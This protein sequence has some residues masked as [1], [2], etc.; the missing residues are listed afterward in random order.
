MFSLEPANPFAQALTDA[1]DVTLSPHEE[2]LFP[3]GERKLR[4]LVDPRGADAY[5]VH[6]LH[7]GPI[8][9]PHDKL[10]RLTLSPKNVLRS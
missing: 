10:C 9:S 4:P 8:D 6:S 1:L 7:G 2:R 3:D 5:V